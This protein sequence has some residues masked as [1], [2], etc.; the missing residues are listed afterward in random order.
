MTVASLMGL[1]AGASLSDYC[2]SKAAVNNFA[3]SLRV[4]PRSERRC[5]V[6]DVAGDIDVLA[7]R[8][9]SRARSS[10]SGSRAQ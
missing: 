10:S 5:A 6:A 1:V 7:G 4:E 3:A 8:R 2:A 9:S